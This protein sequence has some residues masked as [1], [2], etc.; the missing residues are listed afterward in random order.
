MKYPLFWVPVIMAIIAGT[1]FA[2]AQDVHEDKFFS[3]RFIMP[4]RPAEIDYS[5]SFAPMDW[6]TLPP[7]PIFHGWP[8][9]KAG[10][11]YYDM[12]HNS[13]KGRMI[14]VDPEGGVHIA[15]MDGVDPSF[16]N[17]VIK[18]NYFH[19]DSVGS[20]DYPTGW[21]CGGDGVRIDQREYAGYTNISVN[22]DHT[23]PTIVYHDRGADYITNAALDGMYYMVDRTQRCSFLTADPKPEPYLHPDD[24]TFDCQAIWPKIAQIDTTLFIVST[25]SNDTF[26]VLGEEVGSRLI[27]YRGFIQPVWGGYASMTF[28]PPVEIEDDQIGVSCDIAAYKDSALTKVAMAYIRTDTVLAADP[29]SYCQDEGLMINLLEG[30]KLMVRRSSDM[31]A[32]WSEPDY[33]TEAIPHILSGYPDSMISGWQMH[34]DSSA[35]PYDT[36]YEIFKTPSFTRPTNLN[37]TYSPDGVLHVVWGSNVMSPDSGWESIPE[38]VCS[39]GFYYD[40][41]LYHWDEATGRLDTVVYY[42]FYPDEPW[43]PSWPPGEWYPTAPAGHSRFRYTQIGRSHE[44]QVTVD[45]D[46]NI[47]CFWEQRWS[48]L[49]WSDWRD[50]GDTLYGDMAAGAFGGYPNSEIYCAVYARGMGYWSDPL[51]VSNTYTAGCTTDCLSEIEVTLADRVDYFVHLAFIQ[52]HTAGLHP[53]PTGTPGGEGVVTLADVMY[54]RLPKDSL[55]AAAYET[56]TIHF[57]DTGIVEENWVTTPKTFRLGRNFPNPFNAATNFWF[58]VYTPGHY[59]IDI[60]DINGRIVS[61][62]ADL[63]LKDGRH[64]FVWDGLSDNGWHV[65]S[66]I[67]FLRAR[68]SN[69]NS[70]SRKVTL[71]K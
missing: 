57:Y 67:Y 15:W 18:Y 32:T 71:I 60:V 43:P 25:V 20:V 12:Q 26:H 27:Y 13:T 19:F 45:G 38:G 21:L 49:W 31:G 36:T 58:D 33:I 44:P 16:G 50:T 69:G 7:F 22:D 29:T 1:V 70:V 23:V 9:Y 54:L 51:L 47:F 68:D 64:S 40:E 55:I 35:T 4:A 62:L 28:E 30:A 48:E 61:R 56:D 42:P 34:I 17:R 41:V 37:I 39:V 65:P 11:T 59:R 53:Y 66:G 52:D 46:G 14:A 63:P 3:G 10:D 6:D 2:Q 5:R 8:I 24:S